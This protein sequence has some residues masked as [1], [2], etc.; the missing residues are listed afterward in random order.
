MLQNPNFP[1]RSAL[2]LTFQHVGNLVGP[3]LVEVWNTDE[4][5]T[6]RISRRQWEALVQLLHAAAHEA[7]PAIEPASSAVSDLSPQL[8]FRELPMPR[9]EDYQ[10]RTSPPDGCSRTPRFVDPAPCRDATIQSGSKAR[11]LSTSVTYSP[12]WVWVAPPTVGST[13]GVGNDPARGAA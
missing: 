4:D 2:G 9:T 12:P 5:C 10:Q 13:G 8:V 7:I 6:Y 11:A 1:P 3:S